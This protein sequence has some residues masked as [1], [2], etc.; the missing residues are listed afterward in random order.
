MEQVEVAKELDWECLYD[1]LIVRRD[2]AEKQ[3]TD[4]LLK[5]DV[6][7]E[8]QNRGTVLKTGQGRWVDGVLL[9]LTIQPGYK[10]IFSKLSGMEIDGAH[11]DIVLLREDEILAYSIP[12]VG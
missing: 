2:Q 8:N 7:V 9:P 10:V 6:A 1:K 3:Y 12:E 5:P 4:Q 11:P